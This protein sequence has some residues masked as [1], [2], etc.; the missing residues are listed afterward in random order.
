VFAFLLNRHLP[1]PQTPPESSGRGDMLNRDL[2]PRVRQHSESAGPESKAPPI[3]NDVL[4]LHWGLDQQ[5]CSCG[6]RLDIRV[7]IV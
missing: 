1:K 5:N 4:E 2:A 3:I 6:D 7:L